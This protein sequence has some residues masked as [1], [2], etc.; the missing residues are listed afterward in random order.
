VKVGARGDGRVEIAHGLAEGEL[1]LPATQAAAGE[2]AAI[3]AQ[4]RPVAPR[5]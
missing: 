1:V 5:T 4:H 3:R 2:G